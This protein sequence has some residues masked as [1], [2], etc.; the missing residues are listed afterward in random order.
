MKIPG[1]FAPPSIV[2]VNSAVPAFAGYTQKAIHNGAD[3][4]LLP[5]AIQSM[6]EFEQYFGLPETAGNIEIVLSKAAV[7]GTHIQVHFAAG[8]TSSPYNM[9]YALQL[10]FANGGQQCLIVSVG[11]TAAGVIDAEQLKKGLDALQ[12]ESSV[13]LIVFPEAAQ[14]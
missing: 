5:V 11:A 4:T 9:Y 8:K 1:S 14:T 2:T 10:F 13:T 12:Q 7:A 6:A 3:C